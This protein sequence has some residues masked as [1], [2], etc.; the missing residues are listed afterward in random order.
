MKCECT[1]CSCGSVL[2]IRH[3]PIRF[4]GQELQGD[5][6]QNVRVTTLEGI[7]NVCGAC[8]DGH[9]K[10]TAPV[11]D[12]LKIEW[13]RRNFCPNCGV[14]SLYPSGKHAE[15]DSSSVNEFGQCDNCGVGFGFVS[16]R[17]GITIRDSVQL[18]SN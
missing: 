3:P 16:V 2:V 1:H 12:K 15:S 11:P 17:D 9:Y 6:N 8:W 13:S 7:V 5:P 4:I 10:R 14:E 18:T